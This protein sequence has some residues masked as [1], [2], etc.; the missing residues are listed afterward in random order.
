MQPI[1]KTA[2]CSVNVTSS[3]SSGGSGGNGSYTVVVS[4]SATVDSG[5]NLNIDFSVNR[6]LPSNCTYEIRRYGSYWC[7]ASL[8][9]TNRVNANTSSMSAGTY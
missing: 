7:S 6:A 9:S 8:V 3:G 5:N 1:N 2:T 4:S